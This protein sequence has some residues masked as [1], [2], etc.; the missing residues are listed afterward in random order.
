MS[1][2][3]LE[4]LEPVRRRQLV[5]EVCAMPRWGSWRAHSWESGWEHGDGNEPA[6]PRWSLWA[7][8]HR[9]GRPGAGRGRG[10][11]A[12]PIFPHRGRG[13][14]SAGTVSRIG[15]FPP[16]TSSGAGSRPR[17]TRS[18]SPMPKSTWP[19]LTPE[20]WR[21]SAA[22]GHIAVC[23]GDPGSRTRPLALAAGRRR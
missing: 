4:K 2:R 14:R 19:G 12:R 17:C 15:F 16:S 11:V 8:G 22:A 3:I 9:D 5:L 18:R 20:R 7:A 13:D 21:R 1:D 10:A 23:H 6:R